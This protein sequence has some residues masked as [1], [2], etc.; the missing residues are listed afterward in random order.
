MSFSLERKEPGNEV[1]IH[2][3]VHVVFYSECT[4]CAYRPVKIT[5]E[6]ENSESVEK[7]FKCT[8]V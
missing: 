4:N 1:G 3:V 8:P 7:L 6:I 5:T 2:F